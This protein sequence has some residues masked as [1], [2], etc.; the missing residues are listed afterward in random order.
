MTHQSPPPGWYPSGL[1]GELRWWDGQ[2]WTDHRRVPEVQLAQIDGTAVSTTT[3]KGIKW[4]GI[5]WG[6]GPPAL[7]TILGALIIV[8]SLGFL[9]LVVLFSQDP[10]PGEGLANALDSLRLIVLLSGGVL[11]GLVAVIN[12]YFG[13]KLA[14]MRREGS[15]YV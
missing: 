8:P 15:P 7:N 12:G 3:E 6:L 13:L 11:I 4:L 2:Q 10:E 9:A 14:R 5:H 1:S